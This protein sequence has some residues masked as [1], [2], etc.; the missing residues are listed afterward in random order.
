MEQVFIANYRKRWTL[1][2]VEVKC[3]LSR[4]VTPHLS[5]QEAT[6]L[7]DI[8]QSDRSN[9]RLGIFVFKHEVDGDLT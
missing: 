4:M 1:L 5:A 3:N 8:F 9:I 6:R 2:E 7:A